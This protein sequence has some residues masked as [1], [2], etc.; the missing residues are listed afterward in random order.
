M[1][2]REKFLAF[3]SARIE[4]AVRQTMGGQDVTAMELVTH[5][6][7]AAPGSV[8]EAIERAAEVEA[9]EG[10]TWWAAFESE[11]VDDDDEEAES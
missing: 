4:A 9:D 3:I 11:T 2:E 8:D 1:L 6:R 5:E 7:E 10:E